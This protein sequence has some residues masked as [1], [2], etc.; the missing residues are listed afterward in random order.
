MIHDLLTLEAYFATFKDHF[1]IADFVYGNADDI[2]NRKNNVIRYPALWLELMEERIDANDHV[3][4][5]IR[6]T[7]QENAG[8]NAREI[9]RVT[10]NNLRK[11]LR[12]ILQKMRDDSPNK[13]VFYS[14]T[15][16]FEYKEAFANDNELLAQVTVTIGA[17]NPCE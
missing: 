15:A 13:L 4:F 1:G 7:L 11:I 3:L 17:I 8:N 2:L 12:Q 5:D 16:R 14:T 9:D 6:L 10:V